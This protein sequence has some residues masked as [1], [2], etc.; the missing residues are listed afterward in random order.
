[1]AWLHYGLLQQGKHQKAKT[2]LDE[3]LEFVPKDPTKGAR[4]Y[5]VG[6]QSRH[7]I[8]DRA[9]SKETNLDL[10]VK[11]DD[12]GIMPQSVRSFLRAQIAFEDKDTESLKS[13]V[14]WLS[15][16]ITTASMQM[17]DDGLVMCAAGSSRY[18]PNE[19][20]VKSAQVT[21][22]QIQGLIAL[23]ENDQDKFR[24]LMEEATALEDQTNFPTGPPN[25]T[26]PSFEQYGDWLLKQGEYDM[27]L[28]QFDKSLVRMPRRFKSLKGRMMALKNLNLKNQVEIV[29]KELETML[30]DADVEAKRFLS[31]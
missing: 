28:K 9:I 6:M 1:M 8:E 19:N 10:D 17:E 31:E 22:N 23:V 14:D 12:I 11:V 4:G 24:A 15:K 26:M 13:E 20:S 25:V 3:M 30:A 7:L 29:E 27:A 2:V 5:L 18:A 21:L 16:K